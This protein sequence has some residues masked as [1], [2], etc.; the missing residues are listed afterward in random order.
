MVDQEEF[1]KVLG[2]GSPSSVPEASTS[3]EDEEFERNDANA[4]TLYKVSD[5]SGRLQ[6]DTIS[7]K[8]LRQDMLKTEVS[9][10]QFRT[11]STV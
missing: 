7:I 5:A 4:V 8:P 1:F 10:S 2:S 9:D 11:D 6:V 3:E